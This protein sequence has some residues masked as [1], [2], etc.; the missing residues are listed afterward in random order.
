M[1][2]S[3]KKRSAVIVC[4][5]STPILDTRDNHTYKTVRIG[6][7]V[8]MAENLAFLPAVSKFATGSDVDKYYYV[9][10]YEGVDVSEAKAT[11]NYSAFGVLYNWSAAVSACMNGWHLPSDKEWSILNSFLS[12]HGYVEDGSGFNVQLCNIRLNTGDAGI[13]DKAWFW[14]ASIDDSNVLA[15]FVSPYRATGFRYPLPKSYGL[16]VRCV[17][18][19]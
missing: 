2:C 1:S 14:S 17:K 4:L 5:P 15:R 13:G 6:K 16:P 3:N 18:N 19:E 12:E 10:A 11:A 8:W 7:Q 9:Q